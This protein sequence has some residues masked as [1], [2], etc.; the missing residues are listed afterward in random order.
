MRKVVLTVAHKLDQIKVNSKSY[1][2]LS[3]LAAMNKWAL[4]CWQTHTFFK[5]NFILNLLQFLLSVILNKHAFDVVSFRI[6]ICFM[7]ICNAA[8]TSTSLVIIFG[9]KGGLSLQSFIHQ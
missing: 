2:E 7:K 6:H 4:I 9:T 3:A 1:I 5:K 8:E